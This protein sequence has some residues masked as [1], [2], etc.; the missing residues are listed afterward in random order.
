MCAIGL[1]GNLGDPE[2]ML[3]RAINLMRLKPGLRVTDLSS[4]WLTEP[5]GGQ[6]DQAWYFNR[7]ALLA[8]D[9]EA[10][11]LLRTLVDI[12]G[13]LGRVRVERWGPRLIDLDLLFRDQQIIEAP[14]LTLPHPRLHE[15]GFVLFP[16]AEV[17]PNW[18]HPVLGLTVSEL[19]ERL[20]ED[21]PEVRKLT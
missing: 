13:L 21:G 6:A 19:L 7:V 10:I 14:E 1:G 18:C 20:P 4:T 15:R 9:L 16:L 17:A 11:P 5:M 12:E 8:T 2:A 3:D